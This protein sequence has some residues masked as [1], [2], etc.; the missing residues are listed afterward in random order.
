MSRH[1]LSIAQ[2]NPLT[3]SMLTARTGTSTRSPRGTSRAHFWSCSTRASP[4]LVSLHGLSGTRCMLSGTS[5]S[6]NLASNVN[7]RQCHKLIPVP[8]VNDSDTYQVV[9]E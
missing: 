3:R 1:V 7:V 8:A 2:H 4:H 5:P 6:V 9:C